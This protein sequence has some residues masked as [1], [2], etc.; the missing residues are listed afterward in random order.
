MSLT[1]TQQQYKQLEQMFSEVYNRATLS[2]EAIRILGTSF[3]GAVEVNGVQ[4][5]QAQLD[6]REQKLKDD[7][8]TAKA[9]LIPLIDA[10]LGA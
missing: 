7:W 2:K 5:T 3:D 6:A 10:M 8:A 9:N 1:I 4:L